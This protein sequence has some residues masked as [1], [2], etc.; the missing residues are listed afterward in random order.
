MNNKILITGASGQLGKATIEFLLSKGFPAQDIIAFVRDENKVSELKAK[1]I[2]IRKGEY[3]NYGSMVAAFKG[4]DKL[5][6]ISGTDIANRSNQQVNA[7]RAAKESGVK[8]IYYTSFDRKNDSNSSPIAFLAK[9]HIDTEEAI[10]ASGL[11]YTIMRNNLYADTLPMFLGEKVL[12]QGIFFPAGETVSSFVL[13]N[14][15]AE[16]TANILLSNEFDNKSI[17]LGNS[18]KLSISDIANHLSDVSGKQVAYTSPDKGTYETVLAEAGVPA[19]Y[20]GMFSGFANAI[21]DG[22]FDSD[23]KELENIL[24]R[25]PVSAKAFL[26]QVYLS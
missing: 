14:D 6:L 4:V 10:K 22:E 11:T 9:S 15:L 24:G 19:E 23:S 3:D 2:E 25:K 7:V 17:A 20:I 12:E 8:H 13:R 1:G 26:Q 5:L 18:E 21:A 16:A